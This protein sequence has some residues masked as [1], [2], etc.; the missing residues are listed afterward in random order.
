MKIERYGKAELG[1][2]IE[3]YLNKLLSATT[4]YKQIKVPIVH[5]DWRE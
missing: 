5:D 4:E 2:R 1:V 3:R